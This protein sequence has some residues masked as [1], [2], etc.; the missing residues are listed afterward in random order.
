MLKLAVFNSRKYSFNKKQGYWTGLV[1]GALVAIFISC[2]V[3]DT[4]VA[5]CGRAIAFLRME[6][7]GNHTKQICLGH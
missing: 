4:Y 2:A 6:N 7:L 3:F 1:L 5:A